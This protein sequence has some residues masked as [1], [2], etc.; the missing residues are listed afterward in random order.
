MKHPRRNEVYRD[1]GSVAR[2]PDDP[3]FID[4]HEI[5]FPSDGALLLCSD[6]LSDVLP[7]RRILRI[8]EENAGDCAAAVKTLVQEAVADGK[9]NVSV[10][11][12]EGEAFQRPAP[13]RP[14]APAPEQ[15]RRNPIAWIAL[16]ALLGLAAASAF[17]LSRTPAKAPAPP[18]TIHVAPQGAEFASIPEAIIH[19][20]PGDT[21]EL[22]PGAYND[23]VILRNGLRIAGSRAG[24]AV[25][26]G[27]ITA[28]GVHDVTLE[29]F[30][31][32]GES[33][34]T[35]RN[36]V[37]LIDRMR[38]SGVK[39]PGVEFQ[40]V[41]TGVLRASRI[42]GN[43]GAGVVVRDA[44]SPVIE[45]TFI[46]GNGKDRDEPKPGIEFLSSGALRLTAN[47]ISDNGAEPLWLALPPDPAILAQNVL[48]GAKRP[49]R[50]LKPGG[51]P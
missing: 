7:S 43:T 30:T 20:N 41:S 45:N 47:A 44:A 17:F 11:L 51:K 27:G 15:P 1:V 37:V 23:R 28:D 31:L 13:P 42:V 33:G 3:D 9:D 5:K 21:I 12:L 29:G 16:G 48:Q 4:V 22:A 6:G 49:Y 18:K 36:S 26:N 25:L 19:T 8:V 39:G 40:G 35:V 50:V 14:T 46:S 2:T 38:I 34:I 32:Q 10:V 24:E